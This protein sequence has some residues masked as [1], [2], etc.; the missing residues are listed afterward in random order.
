[1]LFRSPFES[2]N[3]LQAVS[4]YYSNP[5]GKLLSMPFNS[6]TPILYWNKTI[7]QKA[8][9][10]PNKAPRTWPEVADAA[11]KILA[12]GA[13][14]CG[15]STQWQTWI[16]I[17]NFGA[18]HNI[19]FATKEN[20]FAGTNVE[21]TIND[22]QYVRHIETL[23]SWQKDKIFSYGG[24][25]DKPNPKFTTGECAMFMG[26][27]GSAGGFQAAMKDQ[28]FGIS[29]LPYWPEFRDAPQNSI[30]GGATLWV[31]QGKPKAEYKGVAKFLTFLSKPEVQAKWHQETGYVPITNAAYELTKKQGFYNKFPGR[32]VAVLQLNNKPPT[33]NSKGLRIGNFVQIRDV[34]DEELEAVWAGQK[35]AKAAVDSAK[36]RGDRLVKDFHNA[37]K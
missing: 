36:A 1:M 16:Q 3:Y 30:I 32:D 15:F 2:K 10:D 11:K 23:A 26:S 22:T 4:S 35:T 24:R 13:A 18:W 25:E 34:V 33:M 28:Q 12:I 8:G 20:G 14:R 29:F 37:N 17:E 6:S 27:S 31:L 5:D 21:L 7:F 19:Q 9:L